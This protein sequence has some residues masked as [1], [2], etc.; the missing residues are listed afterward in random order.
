MT[1]AA[2]VVD[3]IDLTVTVDI[4]TMRVAV[5]GV[6]DV[7]SADVLRDTVAA[8]PELAG[9]DIVLDLSRLEFLDAA[10]MS[11]LVQLRQI[12]RLG[13]RRLRLLNIPA[14]HARVLEIAGLGSLVEGQRAR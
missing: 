11:G 5:S 14:R 6:L 10:G 7:S 4:A 8:L 3:P 1:A 13:R 12:L 9:G 2:P